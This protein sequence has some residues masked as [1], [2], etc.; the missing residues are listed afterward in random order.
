MCGNDARQGHISSLCQ[1]YHLADLQRTALSHTCCDATSLWPGTSPNGLIKSDLL[2][3]LFIYFMT[4]GYTL[5]RFTAPSGP[6]MLQ[7]SLYMSMKIIDERKKAYQKTRATLGACLWTLLPGA[8]LLC[9]QSLQ[10]RS[11]LI[12][13]Y[14]LLLSLF[15]PPAKHC[16]QVQSSG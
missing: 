13:H 8:T 16:V 10:K 11:C 4:L 12:K 3:L 1:Q 6:F 15:S 5:T 9:N 2:I 7:T 14:S